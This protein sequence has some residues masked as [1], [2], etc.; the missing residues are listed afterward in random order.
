MEGTATA[1]ALSPLRTWVQEELRWLFLMH[2]NEIRS[3]KNG[4]AFRHWT[5]A[6]HAWLQERWTIE[7]QD[8]VKGKMRA[9][10]TTCNSFLN[11]VVAKIRDKGGLAHRPFSS[12]DLPKAGGGAFK[13][14]GSA[15]LP[16][17]GDFYQVGTRGGMYKHVGIVMEMEGIVWTT[18]E[19]GQGG[20]SAS[21]DAIKKKGPR[22]FDTGVMGWLDIDEYFNGWGG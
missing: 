4:E 18:A 14:S 10:T 1:T 21:F 17:P 15:G 16:K 7:R 5:G 2:G 9:V 19:A 20:P 3:D 11:V 8:L 6:S 13:W 12:F 22:V